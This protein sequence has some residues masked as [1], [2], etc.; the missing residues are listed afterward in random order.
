MLINEVQ[1][2]IRDQDGLCKVLKRYFDNLFAATTGSYAPVLNMVHPVITKTDNM[3]LTTPILKEELYED[4]IQMHPDKSRDQMDLIQHFIKN[5]GLFVR[6][7]FLLK[8]KFGPRKVFSRPPLT[9]PTDVLS[10]N[11]TIRTA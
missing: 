7:V 9:T 2:K 6:R 1:I 3:L 10:Q 8:Q 11:V 5:S 4:L